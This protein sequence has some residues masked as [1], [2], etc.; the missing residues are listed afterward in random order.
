MKTNLSNANR[1]KRV[2]RIGENICL[3]SIVLVGGYCA[4]LAVQPAEAMAVLQRYMPQ[5]G[6]PAGDSMVL[7]AKLVA[8]IPV[9]VFLFALW[10][11][12]Q[13]FQ[14]IGAGRFLERETQDLMMRLGRLAIVLA[15]LGIVCRTLV[16]LAMTSG[17]PPGQK[18]LL[19]EISSSEISTLIIAVLM[20]VFALLI[21]ESAAIQKENESIV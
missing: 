5:P 12:R 11:T 1:M 14:R 21:K 9:L 13:L 10:R 20:F 8:V 16:V 3:A 15:V 6:M 19:I 17:N 18:M 7:L 2:A 4:F